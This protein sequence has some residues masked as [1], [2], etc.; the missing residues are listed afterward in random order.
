MDMNFGEDIIQTS[1][2]GA[3]NSTGIGSQGPS[4]VLGINPL[5][6]VL[7]ESWEGAV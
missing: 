2:S 3:N 7:W 6:I 5:V 4:D 1:I